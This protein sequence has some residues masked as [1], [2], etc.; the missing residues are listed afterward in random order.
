MKNREEIYTVKETSCPKSGG[1]LSQTWYNTAGIEDHANGPAVIRYD[2][3]SGEVVER[4]WIVGGMLHRPQTEGPAVIT[5]DPQSRTQ[6]ESYF[7]CDKLHR[8]HGPA[9]LITNIDTG[10]VLQQGFFRN[11]LPYEQKQKYL[12][13]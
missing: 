5:F 6:R 8:T 3:N 2:P 4:Q 9:I 10:E 1:L 11:G 13:L 12:D 7:V